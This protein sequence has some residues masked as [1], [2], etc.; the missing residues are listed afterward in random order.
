MS[1]I[2]TT[3]L[4]GITLFLAACS[5]DRLQRT[6]L[7][8]TSGP[9][10]QA[11]LNWAKDELDLQRV[12]PLLE[13]SHN[14]QE[15]ETYLNEDDG[16][17]NLD[18]N[19]DGYADYLSVEEFYDR[20]PYERGLSV[21]D[22]FGPNLIQEVATIVFYRDDP[23]W[24]GARVLVTG[25]D[26]I[27]GDNVYY[28]TNWYD[29]PVDMISYVYR[30]HVAYRSPYYYGYYPPDYV[31]YEVVDTPVYVTR[32]Q[33]LYPQPVLVYTQKP[34]FISKIKI[35]SPNSDKHFDQIYAKLAKPTREQQKFFAENKDKK[36]ERVKTVP[37][38]KID[39]A[40]LPPGKEKVPVAE[41]PPGQAKEPKD[42][43]VAKVN[44]R[45]PSKPMPQAAKPAPQPKPG[46]PAQG[47]GKG[48]K[49]G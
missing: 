14:P 42:P 21:Y 1:I 15:F 23:S 11:E 47:G 6:D 36:R 13:R 37:P 32:V 18:L 48:K 39:D 25:N 49:K 3:I 5:T 44:P 27:Y 10:A 24:P 19:G 41:K 2:R 30:P 34:D 7:G 46:P 28:E 16:I 43:H 20:G 29:R 9:E 12:G 26:I 40:K 4:I 8:P 22:S 35:K 45:K 38:R 31:V 33:Q 17:N